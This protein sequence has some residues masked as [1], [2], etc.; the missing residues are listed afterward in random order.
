MVVVDAGVDHGDDDVAAARR[1]VPGLGGVDVG[2]GAAA[3]LAGVV[4]APQLGE[5]RVVGDRRVIDDPV[6]L[7]VEHRGVALIAL[8]GVFHRHAAGH[9]TT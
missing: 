3:G 2:V 6:G 4:H 1:D 9:R 5:A 7:R 8:D